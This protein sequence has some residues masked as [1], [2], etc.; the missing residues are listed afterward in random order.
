VSEVYEL[1]KVSGRE[2]NDYVPEGLILLYPALRIYA[3]YWRA[4]QRNY[5]LYLPVNLQLASKCQEMVIVNYMILIT[6]YTSTVHSLF[7]RVTMNNETGN[8]NIIVGYTSSIKQTFL[9]ST[10]DCPENFDLLHFYF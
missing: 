9:L 4:K 1:E 6:F 10:T 5:L 7:K 8:E 3:P 2:C